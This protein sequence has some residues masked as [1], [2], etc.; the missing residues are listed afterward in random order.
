MGSA[1]PNPKRIL[2]FE[3][4]RWDA[5]DPDSEPHM[6][7]FL[8]EE[9]PMDEAER[10][11]FHGDRDLRYNAIEYFVEL[12]ADHEDIRA[13]WMDE[14]D[15]VEFLTLIVFADAD[16]TEGE[17]GSRLYLRVREK[18]ENRVL[19]AQILTKMKAEDENLEP[20]FDLGAASR[21]GC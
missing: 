12:W 4:F 20:A 16:E 3:I 5:G 19:S 2:R 18:I 7:T 8:L 21:A 17:A 6:D 14:P 13:L 9:E 1:T 11:Q 10:R 15:A